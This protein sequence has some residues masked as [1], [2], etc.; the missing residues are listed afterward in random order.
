MKPFSEQTLYEILEIPAW[1]SR[2]DI[3]RA[4]DLLRSTFEDDALASYSLFSKNELAEIRK[5]IEEAYRVLSTE[6]L[7]SS[8]DG[9][10]PPEIWAGRPSNRA[11]SE[12][13]TERPPVPSIDE[14]GAARAL[15]EAGYSGA[16]LRDYRE[17]MA[18]SLERIHAATRISLPHLAAIEEEEDAALPHEVYLKAY[19]VQYSRCLKLDPEAVVKGYLVRRRYREAAPPR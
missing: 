6:S 3:Q 11:P 13:R 5:K 15:E 8:Y 16:A 19:L 2:S 1:A 7:R 12:A 14:R 18:V 9:T 4:Y 10:L 17:G